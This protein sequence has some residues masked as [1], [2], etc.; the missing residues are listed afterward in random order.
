ME[1]ELQEAMLVATRAMWS[2]VEADGAEGEVVP[3]GRSSGTRLPTGHLQECGCLQETDPSPPAPSSPTP[4]ACRDLCTPR[5][6]DSGSGIA[7]KL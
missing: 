1:C 6:P 2:E 3:E 5:I 4:R 7:E